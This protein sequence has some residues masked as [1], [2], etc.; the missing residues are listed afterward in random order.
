MSLTAS[1]NGKRG[2]ATFPTIVYTTKR[3]GGSTI[4]GRQKVSMYPGSIVFSHPVYGVFNNCLVLKNE[5]DAAKV[6]KLGSPM[7]QDADMP[8]TD[9]ASTVSAFEVVAAGEVPI[10]N[11]GNTS[12]REGYGVYCLLPTE[13]SFSVFKDLYHNSILNANDFCHPLVF[14]SSS[15]PD[16]ILE[17]ILE[18]IFN[19]SHPKELSNPS[20]L[21]NLMSVVNPDLSTRAYNVMMEI[22]STKLND[23]ELAEM[24]AFKRRRFYSNINYFELKTTPAIISP[25]T[26][27][28]TNYTAAAINAQFYGLPVKP[29]GAGNAT[30]G[31]LGSL[32]RSLGHLKV[33]RDSCNGFEKRLADKKVQSYE[34]D[35]IKS[36]LAIMKKR[37]F[38]I[39]Y[40]AR[41]AG[42][43][44]LM[45]VVVTE[46]E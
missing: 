36:L 8:N 46:I 44:D 16:E 9:Y 37:I 29:G 34:K 38:K 19:R 27:D 33:I 39:G 28:T 45:Q 15:T 42:P 14:C 6:W 43:G 21:V 3:S 26:V 11:T 35:Y 25:E 41:N 30:V 10:R 2:Q 31:D 5:A 12:G 32:F 22:E 40:L 17:Y 18:D 4:N 23:L 24:V 20:T 13:N 7:M 1:I